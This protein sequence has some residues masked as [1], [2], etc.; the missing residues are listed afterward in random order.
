MLAL[1]SIDRSDGEDEARQRLVRAVGAAA[2]PQALGACGRGGGRGG[3]GRRGVLLGRSGCNGGGVLA[4]G[5]AGEECDGEVGVEVLPELGDHP[6]GPDGP[7]V[8]PVEL[9]RVVRALGDD[10][11]AEGVDGARGEGESAA[12]AA[13]L[14]AGEEAHHVLARGGAMEPPLE[15]RRQQLLRPARVAGVERLVEAQHQE[16]VALLLRLLPREGG[17]LRRLLRA[18]RRRSLTLVVGRQLQTRAPRRLL[19]AALPCP[20]TEKA[21]LDDGGERAE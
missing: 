16:A 15:V 8:H 21:L 20:A 1:V 4:G 17:Q 9:A 6:I 11:G 14:G 19:E 2:L 5:G 18:R 3:G 7:G 13:F 10:G 12:A